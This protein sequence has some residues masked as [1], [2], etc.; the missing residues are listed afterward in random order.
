M[1]GFK[2][3]VLIVAVRILSVVRRAYHA[4]GKLGKKIV[5]PLNNIGR[6]LLR[7]FLLP[8]Y[9]ATQSLRLWINRFDPRSLKTNTGAI[10]LGLGIGFTIIVIIIIFNSTG[11]IVKSE[12]FGST[13][14]IGS[15]ILPA[16]VTTDEETLW[17]EG[18]ITN[19]VA[20]KDSMFYPEPSA[21]QAELQPNAE[22]ASGTDALALVTG[23]EDSLMAFAPPP[24]TAR[25][26][27]EVESYVVKS[28][29]TVASIARQF[30]LKI[31]TVLWANNLT[32]RSLLKIGQSLTIP[33]VNGVMHLVK[34]GETLASIAAKYKVSLDEIVEINKLADNQI[35]PGISLLIPNGQPL[36]TAVAAKPAAKPTQVA[37]RTGLPTPPAAQVNYSTALLWPTSSHRITQYFG[38]R[39]TGV[40]IGNHIGEPIYAA[41][42]GV[43]EKSQWN[44][45][46]YG[47]YVIINHGNG[48]RT[49]YGHSSKLLVK[50]GQH[51]NRGDVIA[52]IGSTGRSTGPHLHFE[53]IVGGGRK[54]PLT[55][56]R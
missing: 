4:L 34:K 42:D 26:R 49:L 21:L 45:G 54:N 1:A 6:F 56:T 38:W 36:P 13:A 16:D 33:P 30:G 41:D 50:A 46:G 48:T 22:N 17:E 2:H 44:S 47:Y 10:H 19:A 37:Q 3:L 39:H 31:N 7:T 53:V 55:Y 25:T 18:P 8:P 20:P 28:G 23:N 35:K 14:I 27:N 32:Q 15:V 51:V 52:L 12:D 40:D 24:A 9:M 5:N 29:D 43:V 11:N